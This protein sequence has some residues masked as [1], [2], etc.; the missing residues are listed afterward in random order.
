MYFFS[1]RKLRLR[2]I[3]LSPSQADGK[4]VAD[5]DLHQNCLVPESVPV[6]VQYGSQQTCSVL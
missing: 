3:G 4:E 6:T 5:Q 2:E 1:M